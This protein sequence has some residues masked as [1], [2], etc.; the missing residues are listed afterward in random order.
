MLSV[1]SIV[2]DSRIQN[3]ALALR[4]AGYQVVIMSVEDQ[5]LMRGLKDAQATW[6]KYLSQ[7]KGITT[8]R[9]FLKSREWRWLPKIFNKALQAIELTLK[10]GIRVL[11]TKADVY[12]CHDLLPACF[13]WLGKLVHKSRIVYDAHELEIDQQQHGGFGNRVI[14]VY[15]EA[16]M[17]RC[18]A[19]I[20][21][22][23]M[24]AD[25]MSQRYKKNVHIVENR[26]EYI[27]GSLLDASRLRSEEKIPDRDVVIMYV[28]NLSPTR[29]IDKMILAL[30]YLESH[31]KF[32]I[33]GTGRIGEFKDQV[34]NLVK[35]HGIER[36]RIRFIGPYSPGEV[37]HYLT[38]ADLSVL[39]Y[40]P[41]SNNMLFNAPNKLYQ[42]IVAQVPMVASHNKSFP[43][44]IQPDTDSAI[45]VTVD[46]TNPMAI[47]E[48][49]KSMLQKDVYTRAKENLTNK[50]RE[51]SWESEK[52][53]LINIYQK[54]MPVSTV[55]I[56]EQPIATGQ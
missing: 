9:V 53:K 7:T 52:R 42:S 32:Y 29:G 5:A 49:I 48:G 31:V 37:I 54:M 28:G 47:A 36:N 30:K 41:T 35:E 16:M 26:P 55:N 27:A 12:H 14:S 17:R 39:L 21:V 51:V 6:E 50:S 33:M 45:G 56:E 13:A 10:F 25:I 40:Q 11:R 19:A 22:N 24:I 34:D 3:E 23:Q 20:T 43:G 15:E 4:D 44:I 46:S 8:K 38:G 2:F 18:D 1:T